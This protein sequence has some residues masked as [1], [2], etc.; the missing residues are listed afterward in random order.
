[1]VI[2]SLAR[3]PAFVALLR[4]PRNAPASGRWLPAVYIDA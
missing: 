1:M 2:A 3:R 4:L